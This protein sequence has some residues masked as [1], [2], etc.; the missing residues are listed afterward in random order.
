MPSFLLPYKEIKRRDMHA[1]IEVQVL[2][3]QP[4]MGTIIGTGGMKIK[5]LRKVTPLQGLGRVGEIHPLV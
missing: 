1:P 3:P 2:I 4:F 5:D